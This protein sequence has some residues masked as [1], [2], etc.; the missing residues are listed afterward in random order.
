MCPKRDKDFFDYFPTYPQVLSWLDGI[1]AL[2]P[3]NTETFYIGET[4]L[5][6]RIRG[7]KIFNSGQNKRQVFMNAGIHA[8]E[9]ITVTSSLYIVQQLLS[10]RTLLNDFDF[11]IVPVFNVDGYTYTH[12][13]ARLWRKNR[14]LNSGNT[15]VGTDLNRN[16]AFGWG[17][18]GSSNNPCSDTFRGLTP[19]SSPE[20]K[21]ITSFIA[22]LQNLAYYL[23]IHCCGAMFMSSWGFTSALPDDYNE[24]LRVMQIAQTGIR[25][26]NGNT[27]AIGSSNRVIYAASG[28]TVDWAYGELGVVP[29][30]TV[31]VV[32]QF[33]APPSNILPLAREIW[34]GVSAS[35]GSLRK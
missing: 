7:I 11:Y 1:Q 30:F 28:V 4:Y 13:V 18:D 17:R 22:T 33:V 25:S 21:A 2:Y 27:Y 16:F 23:D 6:T 5:K 19:T 14:E 35:V 26:I 20:T 12:E 34:A 32:G 15:C 10:Q 8:R 9:W 24:M 3:Q 29:S 31:E